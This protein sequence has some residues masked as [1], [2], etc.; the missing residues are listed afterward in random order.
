[1]GVVSSCETYSLNQKL[2]IICDFTQALEQELLN[3]KAE[4]RKLSTELQAAVSAKE[5]AD[6]KYLELEKYA[7]E[8]E[9]KVRM[10]KK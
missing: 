4:N 1:M 8:L 6:I 10:I 9:Q 3:C 7:R 5:E 2:T